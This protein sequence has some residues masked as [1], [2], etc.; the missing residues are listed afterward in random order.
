MYEKFYGLR[1]RAFELTPDPRFLIL[2]DGHREA[3]SNLEYGITYRR[4]FTVLIG[5]AGTGKTMIL[6]RALSAASDGHGARIVPIC[7]N[8]PTLTRDEFLEFL[9]IEFRLSPDAIGSK[10]RFL[11]E[12]AEALA[13]RRARGDSTIM[14]IDEA[15][16]LP[17]SLLEE[18]R[19]LGNIESDT[20]KLLPIILVGQPELA[21]RLNEPSLRQLKQRVALRCRLMPLTLRETAGYIAGRIRLAG[22]DAGTVFS[23]N[24]VVAVHQHSQGIPRMISVICDN[25]LLTGFSTDRRPID[26]ALVAEVCADFDLPAQPAGMPGQS[27]LSSTAEKPS[28][29][30]RPTLP[31][32]QV[33]P[34]RS[35]WSLFAGQRRRVGNAR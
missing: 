1:E 19:L 21:D 6:R 2:T 28:A 16:S 14:V 20:E 5:E 26:A 30:M 31:Q 27:E 33:A 3:L 34:G 29:T 7:M 15:Q 9:T 11:R 18:I 22:G 23:S 13:E 17:H 35:G 8:N 25:A 32:P 24:A 10:T 12:A 4:G